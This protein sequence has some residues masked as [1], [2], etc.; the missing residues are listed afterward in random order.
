MAVGLSRR[1][2]AALAEI[3]DARLALEL[4]LRPPPSD[5]EARGSV[6]GPLGLEYLYLDG[7]LA[8]GTIDKEER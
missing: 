1:G 7:E 2:R 5:C 8:S 6:F 4:V 3:S